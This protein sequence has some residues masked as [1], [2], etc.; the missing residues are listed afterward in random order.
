MSNPFSKLIYCIWLK[1]FYEKSQAWGKN[2]F[3]GCLPFLQ[4]R[5][6]VP[7]RLK[8]DFWNDSRRLL[9]L[10]RSSGNRITQTSDVLSRKSCERT[11]SVLRKGWRWKV[12]DK[13]F[14]TALEPVSAAI[15]PTR[16]TW[17]A[18]LRW[19]DRKRP[20]WLRCSLHPEDG[21]VR[22]SE[23]VWCR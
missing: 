2:A 21:I 12:G 23:S 14:A 7:Y 18:L 11:T 17:G 15:D 6:K 9:K 1:I 5:K 10:C 13:I 16:R 20:N 3:E 8:S 19:P 22:I 4:D